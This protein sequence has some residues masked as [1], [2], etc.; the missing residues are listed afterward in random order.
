MKQVEIRQRNMISLIKMFLHDLSLL[1][2]EKNIAK[3]GDI[4]QQR[5]IMANITLKKN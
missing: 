1:W 4:S 3:H 5:Q 2:L